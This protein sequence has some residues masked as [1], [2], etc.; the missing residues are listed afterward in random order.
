MGKVKGNELER[1]PFISQK[2]LAEK[3]NTEKKMCKQG[4]AP[5]HKTFLCRPVVLVGSISNYY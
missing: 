3:W 5:L 2:V 1:M 4:T